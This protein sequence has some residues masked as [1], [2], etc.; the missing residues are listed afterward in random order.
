MPIKVKNSERQMNIDKYRVIYLFEI[1][2]LTYLYLNIK[3]LKL[4][5]IVKERKNPKVGSL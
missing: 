5:L 4:G 3:M 2:I 1:D